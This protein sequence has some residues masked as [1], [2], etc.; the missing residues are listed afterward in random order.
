[1][2]CLTQSL[3]YVASSTCETSEQLDVKARRTS[4]GLRNV[5]VRDIG[6]AGIVKIVRVG[7]IVT[8]FIFVLFVLFVAVNGKSPSHRYATSSTLSGDDKLSTTRE[9]CGGD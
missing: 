9:G 4:I 2:D 8:A 6:P 5:M 3:G 1:M 7:V